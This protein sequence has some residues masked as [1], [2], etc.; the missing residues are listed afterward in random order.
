MSHKE[1][2]KANMV[3]FYD[4]M[5]NHCQPRR[6]IELYAGSQYIQHNPHVP[7]GKEGFIA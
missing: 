1:S 3:A 2:T 5:F 4:P 6:A 7:K